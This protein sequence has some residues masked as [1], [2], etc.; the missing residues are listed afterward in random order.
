MF[1]L[2]LAIFYLIQ[3]ESLLAMKSFILEHPIYVHLYDNYSVF[4]SFG[5][6]LLPNQLHISHS[7][8]TLIKNLNRLT[9][10]LPSFQDDLS[11]VFAEH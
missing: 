7:N 6:L 3:I 4:V 8:F 9:D 2:K 10:G 5:S 1:F 11:I